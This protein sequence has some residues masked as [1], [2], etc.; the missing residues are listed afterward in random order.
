MSVIPKNTSICLADFKSY[1]KSKNLLIIEDENISGKIIEVSFK[2][3]FNKTIVAHDGQEALEVIRKVSNVPI[4]ILSGTED[5]NELI[6]LINMGVSRFVEKPFNFDGMAKILLD[7]LEEQK[8][9]ELIK[10]EGCRVCKLAVADDTTK[11]FEEDILLRF[12][13]FGRKNEDILKKT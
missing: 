2:D 12:K 7:I 11:E 4:I 3:F 6:K 8:Y 1:A 13:N 9:K 10:E 5:K